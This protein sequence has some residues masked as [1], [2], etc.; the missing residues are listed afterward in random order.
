LHVSAFE[1]FSRLPV[2]NKDKISL[3]HGI[4]LDLLESDYEIEKESLIFR[5]LGKIWEGFINFLTF[6]YETYLKGKIPSFNGIGK[7][8][9]LVIGAVLLLLILFVLAPF[10]PNITSLK[11]AMDFSV[12]PDVKVKNNSNRLLS[13]VSGHIN[14][15]NYRMGLVY[16]YRWF[17]CW[18][19]ERKFVRKGDW[20]TNRQLINVFIKRNPDKSDLA[21]NIIKTYEKT[22]Y[23]HKDPDPDEVVGL[24]QLAQKNTL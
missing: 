23:G 14:N 22:E 20:W 21:R 17:I 11:N 16:L 1:V 10:L 2:E 4:F 15:E 18:A 7:L 24:F 12:E 8:F 5:W 19:E 9:Y 6:L 13:Q 3:D